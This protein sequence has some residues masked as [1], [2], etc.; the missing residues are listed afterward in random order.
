MAQLFNEIVSKTNIKII[1]LNVLSW[2]NL[3]RRLWITLYIYDKSP[4][5]ILLNSTSLVCTENN[6]NSLSNIK[7]NNYKTYL[8]KQ[9]IQFGSAILVK[10]N[11]RHSIIP[12]LSPSSIAVKVSTA[13]GPIV[14]FTSY[15]PPRINGINSLDFQKLISINVPLLIAGDFNANHTFFGSHN[16]ASNHRGELLYHICKLYINPGLSWP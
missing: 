7:L 13:T 2:N 15:I 11:L 4:D 3:G 12:N 14:F 5:I 16:R 1:Q 8:T 10:K 9:D 6:R